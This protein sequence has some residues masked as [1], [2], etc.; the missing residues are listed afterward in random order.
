MKMVSRKVATI[1][2]LLLPAILFYELAFSHRGNSQ[3]EQ[4]QDNQSI[5]ITPED[6]SPPVS[7]RTLPAKIEIVVINP[8]QSANVAPQ[9]G[10][11]ILRFHFDEGDFVEKGQ[12]VCELDETRYKIAFDRARERVNELRVAVERL[13]EEAQIKQELLDLDVTTRLEA[14]KANAEF[15]MAKFRLAGAQK[16]LDMARLDLDSCKVKAPF[17]GYIS[18]RQKQPDESVDK[19]QTIFSIVDSSQVYAVAH[20][21]TSMLSSFPKG[22]EAEFL[23]GASDTAKGKVDRI[24]KVIDPKSKTKRVYLLID[25][26]AGNLEVGMTGALQMV[27]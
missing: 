19:L 7:L 4:S 1:A 23:Y 18:A 10:G 5:E 8:F 25:N 3:T 12:V 20:V 14:A 26:S 9:V 6:N 2:M 16:E 27:N 11:L 21:P 22:A 13:E 15:E 24:A 17:S